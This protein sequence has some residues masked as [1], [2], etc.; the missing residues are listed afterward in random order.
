MYLECRHCGRRTHGWDVSSR[1]RSDTASSPRQL[2]EPDPT[3]I[4]ALPLDDP[5]VQLNNASTLTDYQRSEALRSVGSVQ[6]VHEL[7]LLLDD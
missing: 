6:P 4:D 1:V 7:R 3:L 2:S 5:D